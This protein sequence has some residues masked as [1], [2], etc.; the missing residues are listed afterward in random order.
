MK[1]EKLL[2]ATACT[3]LFA[4][5]TV[6]S[7]NVRT[8][9]IYADYIATADGSGR[10]RLE[11]NLRVGGARS[12]TFLEL[13]DGDKLMADHDGSVQQ[14]DKRSSVFGAVTY[15]SDFDVDAKDTKFRIGFERQPH[16]DFEAE[17]RGGGAPDSF[18]TLPA[19]FTL[20]NPEADRSFSR[21]ADNITVSWDRADDGDS[22]RVE[23]HGDCLRDESFEVSD[24]SGQFVIAA[25]R[26]ETVSDED[27]TCRATIEVLRLRPGTIDSAFGEGGTFVARQVRTVRVKSRP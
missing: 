11:A 4:C 23:V 19:P 25:G 12:N 17:C 22:M 5:E 24:D 9:G 10:T 26:L 8:D 3:L 1:L 2:L 20:S 15:A 18:A 16:D 13:I 21:R 7:P 27:P 14:M 6:D